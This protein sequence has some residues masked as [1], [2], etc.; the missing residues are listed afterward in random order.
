MSRGSTSYAASLPSPRRVR[1]RSCPSPTPLV[2]RL[3]LSSERGATWLDEDGVVW[4]CAVR[5]RVEGSDDDAFRWFANLHKSGR[6][7]PTDDDRLR[8]KAEEARGYSGT[9]RV[10]S[11]SWWTGRV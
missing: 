10:T 11:T 9:S 8:D 1:R 3:R 2:Y 4:L 5:R 7:L 6:L